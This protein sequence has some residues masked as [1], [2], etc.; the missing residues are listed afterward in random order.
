MLDLIKVLN[1]IQD[2]ETLQCKAITALVE[3]LFRATI[4]YQYFMLV[5]Y[6]IFMVV[7]SVRASYTTSQLFLEICVLI[8]GAILSAMEII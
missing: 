2:E 4:G 7:L 1:L 5:F 6:S 8:F 3:F